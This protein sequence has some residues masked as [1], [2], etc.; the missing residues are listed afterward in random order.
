MVDKKL[1]IL[2]ISQLLHFQFAWV[3]ITSIQLREVFYSFSDAS[4]S[5][6]VLLKVLNYEPMYAI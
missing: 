6:L 2:G 4:F 5:K 1:R 3:L